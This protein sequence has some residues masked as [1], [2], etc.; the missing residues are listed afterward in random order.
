MFKNGLRNR[1]RSALT[2][3]SIAVSLCVLG[4]LMALYRGLFLAGPATPGQALRLV[5]HHRV[6]ITQP[7]PES[8]EERIRQVPGVRD[9]QKWQWFG[10]TYKDERDQR[11][12]FPRLAIEPKHLFNINPEIVLPEDQQQ[13][14]QRERTACIVGK[15]LADRYGWQIGQRIT[16][17]GDIFPGTYELKIAGIYTDELDSTA[18]FFNWEYINETLKAQGA[19]GRLDQVGAFQMITNT[20][21]DVPRVSKAIDAMFNNSPAPTQTETEQAFFVSFASFL[22]NLKLFLMAICAAITFTILLVCANTISMSVRERVR[23]VGVLKTLGFTRE[24]ILGII[25]GEATLISVIGGAI[26]CVLAALL[27]AGARHAPTMMGFT[28]G[29]VMTP[30]V[31][32]VCIGAAAAI[33]FVSSLIPAWTASRTP[34]VESLR[35][36]G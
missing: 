13:A 6:S 31:I 10:G 24:S 22:G 30:A 14:F 19:T 7:L 27:C 26:G 25:L 34:I 1:R 33:G 36:T 20:T 2:I 8:Y 5:T 15:Q 21:D 4:M 18:L 32:S 3:A 9:V 16:L 11:N 12:F 28:N 17:Q 23:E 35:H 29:M